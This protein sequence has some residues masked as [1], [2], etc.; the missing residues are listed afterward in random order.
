MNFNN[1]ELLKFMEALE[2]DSNRTSSF[3]RMIQVNSFEW[4]S[5]ILKAEFLQ[6][7]GLLKTWSRMREGCPLFIVVSEDKFHFEL[8]SLKICNKLS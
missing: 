6:R 8:I 5:F 3:V 4:S 7:F 2:L 1:L